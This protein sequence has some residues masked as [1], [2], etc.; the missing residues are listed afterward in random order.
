MSSSAIAEEMRRRLMSAARIA[1][2]GTR[3]RSDLE[4]W[5]LLQPGA[6]TRATAMKNPRSA[7][8][9]PTKVKDAARLHVVGF[10]LERANHDQEAQPHA[11]AP[12]T[13]GAPEQVHSR[14]L[15]PRPRT[16]PPVPSATRCYR[17]SA[18]AKQPSTWSDCCPRRTSKLRNER[19]RGAKPLVLVHQRK[20]RGK[21]LRKCQRPGVVN[22]GKRRRNSH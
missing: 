11:S 1:S 12:V 6:G 4:G 14:T 17:R 5:D 8:V 21:A 15:A 13:P 18:T 19:A 7:S 3:A 22:C 2:L 10:V 16:C 20:R 9:V